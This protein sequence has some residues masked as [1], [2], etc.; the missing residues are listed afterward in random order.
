M[1]CHTRAHLLE[2]AHHRE[3]CLCYLWTWLIFNNPKIL[4]QCL[5]CAWISI[6][7][8]IWWW[9]SGLTWPIQ[10]NF[11][12]QDFCLNWHCDDDHINPIPFVMLLLFIYVVKM[13]SHTLCQVKEWS[14]MSCLFYIFI[15]LELVLSCHTKSWNSGEEK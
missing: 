10:L 7:I 13:H 15:S 14:R 9:W 4:I 11:Q 6:M 8:M 5:A 1:S 2:F 12:F 3:K